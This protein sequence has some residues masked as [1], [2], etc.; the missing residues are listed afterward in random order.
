MK[1]TFVESVLDGKVEFEAF[2][3]YVSQVGVSSDVP[4]DLSVRAE[5]HSSGVILFSLGT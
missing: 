1:T 4:T 3:D 2:F 5:R